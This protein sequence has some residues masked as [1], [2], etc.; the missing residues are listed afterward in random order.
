[1]AL[2]AS[3]LLQ[4]QQSLTQLAKA[5]S[6]IASFATQLGNVQSTNIS[7]VQTETKYRRTVIDDYDSLSK[8]LKNQTKEFK[9]VLKHVN[10]FSESVTNIKDKQTAVSDELTTLQAAISAAGVATAQQMIRQTRLTKM[11]DHLSDE[12][13]K[14]ASAEKSRN[15]SSAVI[16]LVQSSA[17]AAKYRSEYEKD[18]YGRQLATEIK[19]SLANIT[20]QIG[21]KFGNQLLEL[22]DVSQ[23]AKFA[24][25]QDAAIQSL[26]NNNKKLDDSNA[27]TIKQYVELGKSLGYTS[28]EFDF[29]AAHL[30]ARTAGT[31]ID[32]SQSS[33]DGLITAQE[34]IATV[35]N[36][37]NEKLSQ[38]LDRDLKS[39]GGQFNAYMHENR[40]GFEKL[41]YELRDIN[42]RRGS[43]TT[44]QGRDEAADALH[45]A[46]GMLGR[47]VIPKM[48]EMLK[49]MGNYYTSEY[50]AL[51]NFVQ[52]NRLTALQLNMTEDQYRQSRAE[53]KA[54]WNLAA[55][56]GQEQL[57]E[58]L[59]SRRRSLEAVYGTEPML[60]DKMGTQ[61]YNLTQL[62]GTTG[63]EVTGMIKDFEKLGM[64]SRMSSVEISDLFF[65]LV[66][67]NDNMKLMNGLSEKGR[68]LRIQELKHTTALV[69]NL[70]LAGESA[71]SFAKALTEAPTKASA[72]SDI[73]GEYGSTQVLYNQMANI[74]Q[75]MGIQLGISSDQMTEL[76]QLRGLQKM[77]VDLTEEQTDKI[78]KYSSAIANFESDMRGAMTS[79]AREKGTTAEAFYA[80]LQP[81]QLLYNLQEFT[82][83]ANLDPLVDPLQ[84]SKIAMEKYNDTQ[85]KLIT[86]TDELKKAFDRQADLA[87]QRA[88]EIKTAKTVTGATT[89]VTRFVEG[90][91]GNMWT[92]LATTAG[93]GV[94]AGGI[95]RAAPAIAEV[96]GP[97]LSGPILGAVTTMALPILG[98]LAAGGALYAGYKALTSEEEPTEDTK[99]VEP[100]SEAPKRIEPAQEAPKEETKFPSKQVT[101]ASDAAASSEML[102]E[103]FTKYFNSVDAQNTVIAAFLRTMVENSTVLGKDIKEWYQKYQDIHPIIAMEDQKQ[104]KTSKDATAK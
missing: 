5:S 4:L 3:E 32:I 101:A 99:I 22:T 83:A 29:L 64:T 54:T 63:H 100:A 82:K 72:T 49:V 38:T 70:G 69:S 36:D 42:A 41:I 34:T 75:T 12:L 57:D 71:V 58:F 14:A 52:T 60:R 103:Q 23:I 15:I 47:E 67:S 80:E 61:L 20:N 86:S 33:F 59:T 17:A 93:G 95:L 65:N 51:T 46:V 8:T 39:F 90:A 45:S 55:Q 66:N 1:M 50:D 77:G 35:I 91:K 19:S 73:M 44:G 62:F 96:I 10:D 16:D 2:S 68:Q 79:I 21:G 76:G 88:D 104:D 40:N 85:G 43:L 28:T 56:S 97:L 11:Y 98:T 87:K 25:A 6:N 53:S 18:F 78:A 26:I 74:A 92:D 37:S 81:N 24:N 48:T 84:E 30:G 31:S 9:D 27:D 13:G 7:S 89:E 102:T 94:I